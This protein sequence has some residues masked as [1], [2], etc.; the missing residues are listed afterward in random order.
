MSAEEA[1]KNVEDDNESLYK[2]PGKEQ[3]DEE[4]E[5]VSKRR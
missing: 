5:R 1:L 3:D 2:Y 4:E